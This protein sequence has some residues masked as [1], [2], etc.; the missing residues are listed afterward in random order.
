MPWS[1]VKP[2]FYEPDFCQESAEDSRC[3][4]YAE[5]VREALDQALELDPGV[6]VMG[7]GVDDPLGMFGATL[8][9]HLKYGKERVFDTPLAENG[10]TGIAIG[11][12]LGGMR[13]VYFHNRPD[14]L[15]LTMDQLV[16]H[17]SKW[18]FM[19]G[20]EVHVP[21][22]VWAC[23]GRGWG[24]GAQHS[25]ALQGL[26]MHIPG[27]KLV[28]PSTCY[29]AKGLML[30]AI[31]DENPVIII[32]YRLNFKHKGMVPAEAYKVPL[33]KGVIRR[34]GKDI[35]LVAVSYMVTEAY[36]A[37]VQLSGMGIDAEVI[38]L[39]SLRPL[40]EEIILNSVAKTG[41]LLVADTGWKTAGVTA[42]IAALVAE[43]GFQWLRAPISRVGCPDVP[44]PAGYTLEAAFYPGM[45]EIMVEAQKLM[46]WQPY[47]NLR[48]L[49][50]MELRET[51][52]S[53][54]LQSQG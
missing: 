25:Q 1:K 36:N 18:S 23:V 44:T 21:L 28:M 38:D 3:L 45:A 37:A 33:G 13:P 41:R 31:A 4:T 7:Q 53:P 52:L 54:D 50:K 15:L 11:A 49:R 29:D 47:P 35:T 43:K 14:F 5:A 30:S 48:L 20:G 34:P 16:N 32:E 40:D 6:F 51:L 46:G 9:L 22:V 17:A 24:S 42:E 2:E 19:F 10:L 39:R 8:N 12:A 26:F 27:L